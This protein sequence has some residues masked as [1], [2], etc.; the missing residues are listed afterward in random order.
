MLA[1]LLDQSNRITN[2]RVLLITGAIAYQNLTIW[3]SEFRAPNPGYATVLTSQR[4]VDAATKII[5]L[6]VTKIY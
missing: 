4:H 5:I 2:S 3:K 6:A 1:I